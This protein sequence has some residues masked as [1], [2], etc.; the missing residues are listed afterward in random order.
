VI[1]KVKVAST[2]QEDVGFDV[3]QFQPIADAIE[4]TGIHFQAYLECILEDEGYR[5][6]QDLYTPT[7]VEERKRLPEQETTQSPQRKISPRLKLRV[8]TVKPAIVK[9]VITY[10]DKLS[11]SPEHGA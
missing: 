11:E 7:T 6:W 9:A 1:V 5:E 3:K 8:E 4:G 2:G 10:L